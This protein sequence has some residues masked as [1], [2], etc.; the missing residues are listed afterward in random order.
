MPAIARINDGT[1]GHSCFVPRP[2][3]LTGSGNVLI[4]GQ[5]AIRVGDAYPLH[6]GCPNTP[7]HGGNVS[8]GSGT[9]N[10]NGRPLARIGD[11]ISCGDT[12]AAGSPTVFAG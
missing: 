5:P 6:G 1:T 7:P 11:P 12:I 9:V 3:A 4:N 2:A 10:V 8:A